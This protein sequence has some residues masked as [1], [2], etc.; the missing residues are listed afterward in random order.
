[1]WYIPKQHTIF[2][3]IDLQ[4]TSEHASSFDGGAPLHCDG[5]AWS[6]L[7]FR[8]RPADTTPPFY[9]APRTAVVHGPDAPVGTS[10]DTN[11]TRYGPATSRWPSGWRALAPAWDATTTGRQE[12]SKR[13]ALSAGVS[14]FFL[15]RICC[16]K[17]SIKESLRGLW[18]LVVLDNV[19]REFCRIKFWKCSF[20][21]M[22]CNEDGSKLEVSIS[23]GVV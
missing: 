9:A 15:L 23:I 1:M 10:V 14:F 20:Y 22:E 8:W 12:E 19:M 21:G 3:I 18:N 4:P 5:S 17:E 11:A 13:G 16:I 2:R 7:P 6:F